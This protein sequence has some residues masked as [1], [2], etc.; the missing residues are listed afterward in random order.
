MTTFTMPANL[1]SS[2][3]LS[4]NA[5]AVIGECSQQVLTWLRNEGKEPLERPHLLALSQHAIVITT[6]LN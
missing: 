1:S 6:Y 4:L 5:P 3:V 2:T